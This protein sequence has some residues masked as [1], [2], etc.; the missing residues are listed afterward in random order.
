MITKPLP[1]AKG[2]HP[3]VT[4]PTMPLIWRQCGAGRSPE[5]LK[6]SGFMAKIE[7][8][9]PSPN[10]RYLH[11]LESCSLKGD[12]EVEKEEAAADEEGD[13]SGAEE[14]LNLSENDG[15]YLDS[16]DRHYSLSRGLSPL[17]KKKAR[18][19]PKLLIM[20]CWGPH[21]FAGDP[22]PSYSERLLSSLERLGDRKCLMHWMIAISNKQ[23]LTQHAL[24]AGNEIDWRQV[25][26]LTKVGDN[27][28]GTFNS[29][30]GCLTASPVRAAA[31][32][33]QAWGYQQEAVEQGSL[34]SGFNPLVPGPLHILRNRM[35]E[36][37]FRSQPHAPVGPLVGCGTP[38]HGEGFVQLVEK[39]LLL[40]VGFKAKQAAGVWDAA[41][42]DALALRAF[43]SIVYPKVCS[44]FC[45]LQRLHIQESYR[46]TATVGVVTGVLSQ[47]A[48]RGG[49]CQDCRPAGADNN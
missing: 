1:V 7:T 13:P 22:L 28:A 47:C 30:S 26:F 6:G 37:C 40:Q 34:D 35:L 27:W 32:V 19:L 42:K 4:C 14:S 17:L 5:L 15:S 20:D 24:L 25:K 16:P 3:A 39:R 2:L 18:R 29:A 46:S 21:F 36:V 11:D 9:E 43:Y 31:L 49:H 23:Y 44:T 10:A 48:S 45:F 33:D 41:L 12:A 8:N 38:R